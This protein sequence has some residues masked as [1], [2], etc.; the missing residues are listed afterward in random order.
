MRNRKRGW[1]NEHEERK[2]TYSYVTLKNRYAKLLI[3]P[4]LNLHCD[5]F[6]L[7]LTYQLANYYKNFK[8]RGT[9]ESV[10]LLRCRESAF[11][12]ICVSILKGYHS[13]FISSLTKVLRDW[14]TKTNHWYEHWCFSERSQLNT[15]TVF[16]VHE[17]NIRKRQKEKEEREKI[18][19][20]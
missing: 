19:N 1:R 14:I 7:N 10:Q 18:K 11:L 2:R 5:P 8:R 4:A 17:S 9:N 15:S 13:L 3:V 12:Y 20:R 16:H 6:Q